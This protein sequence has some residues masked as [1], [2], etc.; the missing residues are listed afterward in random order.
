MTPEE[1]VTTE[2]TMTLE[3]LERK[4]LERGA[5][6]SQVKSKT[7]YLTLDILTKSGIEFTKIFNVQ[8]ELDD[9]IAR[10]DREL[11]QM[12]LQR[13]ELIEERKKIDLMMK[14]LLRYIDSFN[15]ALTEC[16]TAEG[17]DKMRIAQTFVNSVDINTPYDN[18][19]FIKA[20]G[21]ILTGDAIGPL[22]EFEKIEPPQRRKNG[23]EI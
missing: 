5:N 20:L 6:K 22:E 19:A 15:K 18:T 16:E 12:R 10:R 9:I 21:A 3:E 8:K 13:E 11:Y 14:D 23:I 4:L 1:T 2:G 7:L 17:R